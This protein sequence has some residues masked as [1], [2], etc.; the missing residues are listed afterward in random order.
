MIEFLHS[1]NIVLHSAFQ[2][3]EALDIAILTIS[4]F[5]FYRVLERFGARKLVTG[6]II[7]AVLFIVSNILDLTAIAWIYS[8]LSQVAL[9]AV[10]IIFQPE[11]RRLF[12]GA[13]SV[14]RRSQTHNGAE[15]SA[16]IAESLFRLA[17][18][19]RGAI[20][21][22]PGKEALD[23]LLSGGTLLN[24]EPSYQLIMSIF[25]PNSPGHDGAVI[26]EKGKLTS[27]GVRLPLTQQ[28]T[29]PDELGTRHHAAMGLAEQSDALVFVVSEESGALR[30]FSQGTMRPLASR[31]DV[32]EI[33]QSHMKRA[34]SFIPSFLKGPLWHMTGQVFLCFALAFI[35][36]AGV[37]LLQEDMRETTYVA[38]VLYKTPKNLVLTGDKPMEIR[39]YLLGPKTELESLA[40]SGSGITVD[41]TNGKPGKNLFTITAENIKLPKK[42]T[43][44][45]AQPSQLSLA[46]SELVER[47]IA[48]KPQFIGKVP[49]G[50]ILESVTVSPSKVMALTPG[51]P[52]GRDDLS[53]MTTPIFLENISESTAL[54]CKITAPPHIQ[55]AE[56][57]WPDVEV[58]IVVRERQTAIKQAPKQ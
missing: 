56:R 10:I 42:V 46:L 27:F 37:G 52:A 8:N 41:L 5:L 50:V 31:D 21:V 28:E 9:I 51:G 40:A 32:V 55:P 6:L 1:L 24:A 47:E 3:R 45:D 11:L 16:V 25:D 54:L 15:I 18:Q 57:R 30:V 7:V 49:R 39:L 48:V 33:L 12:E 14:R 22:V 19:R 44:L 34:A 23:T 35:V 53:V 43:I 2:W 58:S 29:L 26:L 38:Q 4:F 17:E 36:W 13:A 20:V